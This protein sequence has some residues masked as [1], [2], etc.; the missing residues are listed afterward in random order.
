MARFRSAEA[1]RRAIELTVKPDDLFIATYPKCGTTWV[2]QIVHQLR[3]R[4]SMDFAE[5]S[6]VVPWLES[7]WDMGID[8]AADQDW[9]PRAFK[10]HFSWHEIPKGGRYINVVR[11]P[12]DVIVSFYRFFEGWFFEPG[13][14]TL[15]DFGFNFFLTGT[16][17]GRY[18]EHVKAWWPQRTRQDVLMLAY[19]NM[20]TDPAATVGTIGDFLG[21]EDRSAVDIAV[22]QSS[23]EFMLGHPSKFDEHLTRAARD[24]YWGLPPGGS[25]TKVQPEGER[26]GLSDQLRDALGETW[27]REVASTLGLASYEDLREALATS[28]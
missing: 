14:I 24:E 21:I 6:G 18:W 11:D 20:T 8:P 10:S 9:T 13:S 3:S 17:S 5:I 28:E 4:G 22:T 19:E 27:D 15:D 25:S 7:A 12:E 23:R 26:P 1:H 2:Q 16:K